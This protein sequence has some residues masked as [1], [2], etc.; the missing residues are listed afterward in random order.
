MVCTRVRIELQDVERGQREDGARDDRA[1][2]AADAGD[3]D[4]FE[5]RG[6][7]PVDARQ[8]DREDRDRDGGFHDLSDLQPGV[9]RRD[10]EDDAEHHAPADGSPR[11]LRRIRGRADDG[12]V[13]LAWLQPRIGICRQSNVF[14]ADC[15]GRTAPIGWGTSRRP[16]ESR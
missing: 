9:G 11:G 13:S 1:R 4:V 15:G 6:A 3:D 12:L 8:A 7:P 5:T 14:S 10:G 2:Q 16:R